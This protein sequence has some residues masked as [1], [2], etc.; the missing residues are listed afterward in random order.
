MYISA[1]ILG[2]IICALFQV[3]MMFTKLD[4]PR[5]L[6]LG[7]ALGALLTPFGMMDALGQ[8]GGAGLVIMVMTAGNAV[9]GATVALLGGNPM[10]IIMIF[11]IFVALTIIGLGAGFLHWKVSKNS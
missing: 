5:I 3:F 2:G 9:A 1:F 8:W 11:G 6:I 7:F 10:P 4:P